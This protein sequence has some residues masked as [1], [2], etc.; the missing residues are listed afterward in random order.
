[1]A[2]Q[3]PLVILTLL[4]NGLGR[5]MREWMR[6]SLLIPRFSV[7]SALAHGEGVEQAEYRK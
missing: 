6:E 2:I 5:L 1:M 7:Y 4:A 3:A